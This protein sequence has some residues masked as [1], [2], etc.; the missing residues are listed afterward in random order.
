MTHLLH[1]LVHTHSQ[2]N[3]FFYSQISIYFL[4]DRFWKTVQLLLFL[5][6]NRNVLLY[7]T[8]TYLKYIYII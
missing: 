4:L 7:S 3:V 8:Q 6:M 2:N 5:N 1:F